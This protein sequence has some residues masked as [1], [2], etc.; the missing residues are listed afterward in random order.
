MSDKNR[1]IAIFG[2]GALG[3]YVGGYLT[4]AGHDVTMIDPWDE[5]VAMMKEPGL[6]LEGLT[7]PENFQVKTNAVLP[8]D[9]PSPDDI[10]PFDIIFI[11]V[12]SFDT[13]DAI[14][15]IA[16]YLADDGFAVSL[17]NGINEDQIVAVV[18]AERTIGCIASTIAVSLPAA[19]HIKRM[20][21]LGGTAHTVFRV[22]ELDGQVTERVKDIADM[23][24][25]IDSAL[26]T[27]N[28]MG[29]RWAKL[30]TNAMRNP[31]AA[32]RDQGTNQND[33]D[34]HVRKLAVLIAAE[35]I[36]VAQAEGIKLVKVTGVDADLLCAAGTGDEAAYEAVTD[37]FFA[38]MERRSETQ[39][40]SMAQD[41]NKGR[42]TEIDQLNGFIVDRAKKYGI[43][44]PIN[45]A[46]IAVIKRI[47]AGEITPSPNN[48]DHI[49]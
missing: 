7:E 3:G 40:P 17:Q 23:L 1:K 28:L 43:P 27:E 48:L 2:C 5:H 12:K 14:K 39:R 15:T 21:K 45:E 13:D 16:P 44:T 36:Q 33:R 18:G 30:A 41:I 37:K 35:A 20:V 10:P 49:K 6:R 22:G 32:A 4:R 42:K 9:L 31:V 47:E 29:E 19:G 26:V 46:I 34:P 8:S 38:A 11:T 25:L 24:S